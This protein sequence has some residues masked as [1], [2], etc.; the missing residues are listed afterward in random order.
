M[1]LWLTLVLALGGTA[2]INAV[3]SFIFA[4]V[5]NGTKKKQEKIKEESREKIKEV[6]QTELIPVN[7]ELQDIKRTL[8]LDREGTVTL[9][10]DSMKDCLDRYRDQGYATI[11]DKAKWIETYNSYV[12]LGGNHFR[13]YVDQWKLALEHLPEKEDI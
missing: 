12:K 6:L 1:P 10:R 2:L 4:S 7:K 8:D 5:I 9:L 3:V 11:S 13:E